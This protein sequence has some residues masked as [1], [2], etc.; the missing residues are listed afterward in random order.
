M[1]KTEPIR[2][3]PLAALTLQEP[4]KTLWSGDTALFVPDAHADAERDTHIPV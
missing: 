4:W 3:R 2:A 1:H